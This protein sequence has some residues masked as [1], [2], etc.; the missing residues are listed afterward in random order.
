MSEKYITKRY[1]LS[2]YKSTWDKLKTKYNLSDREI[3]KEI[4][5]ALQMWAW[6]DII[7]E[8]VEP[9]LDYRIKGES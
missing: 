3:R 6:S 1:E 4:E 2:T 9:H 5:E 7:T 8:S